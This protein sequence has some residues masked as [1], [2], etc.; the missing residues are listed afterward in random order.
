[1]HLS[2]F[3]VKGKTYIYIDEYDRNQGGA[4]ARF[5]FIFRFF[6]APIMFPRF[7]FV[8]LTMRHNAEF[9]GL[10]QEAYPRIDCLY[11]FAADEMWVAKRPEL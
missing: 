5:L 9:H 6:I 10:K 7:L 2:I 4:A 1:M 3:P 8:L 11:G